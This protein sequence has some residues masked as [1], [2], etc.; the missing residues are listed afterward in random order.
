MGNLSLIPAYFQGKLRYLIANVSVHPDFRRRGIARYLAQA[1]LAHVERSDAIELWLQ[2]DQSNNAALQL[3]Q[4]MG[5][6]EQANRTTWQANPQ[7]FESDLRRPEIEIR[8]QHKLDWASHLRWLNKLYPH[9]IRWNL[10]MDIKQFQPGWRGS[11]QRFLGE[12]KSQQ[13]SA[14][15]QE[16]LVGI[17]TWQSSSLNADRIWIASNKENEARAI[18]S[19]IA[20]SFSNLR[21]NRKL[22]LDFPTGRADALLEKTGFTPVRR[23]IWMQHQS[24]PL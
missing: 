11:F 14:V 21:S 13:W 10:P 22:V 2:V 1:A 24:I 15:Q 4:S 9:N 12:R 3:Y 19:L 6:H 8:P 17:L 5:F 20:H 7:K 16:K 23:L 18:P